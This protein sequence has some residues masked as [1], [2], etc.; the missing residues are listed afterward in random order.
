MVLRDVAANK[1]EEGSF[2]P[3]PGKFTYSLLGRCHVMEM[4]SR[5]A[6]AHHRRLSRAVLPM[7]YTYDR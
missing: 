1:N 2:T 6:A 7:A 4:V 5:L 3:R